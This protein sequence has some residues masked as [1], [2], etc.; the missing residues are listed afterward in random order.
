[1]QGK[2]L[3]YN[4]EFKSGLIRG[5]DGNK[6]RFS[7]DDCKSTMSPKVGADVDF[8]P[9]GDKAIEVY[10]LDQQ[11]DQANTIKSETT[12]TISLETQKNLI[13]IVKKIVIWGVVLFVV[14]IISLYGY[15][16][17]KTT[18]LKSGC[19][20]NNA[21]A[22]YDL[23]S[24]NGPFYSYDERT[25]A[26]NKACRLGN[27]DGCYDIFEYQKACDLKLGK[28]CYESAQRELS[29]YYDDSKT[30]MVCSDFTYEMNR[31]YCDK[32]RAKLLESIIPL[33]KLA[34]EY[35]Y[36]QGCTQYESYK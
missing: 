2:I 5:E 36:E 34:C 17:I 11:T 9:N 14:I 12:P 30:K 1:M 19:E 20:N 25:E 21:E 22:C 24:F 7:I 8:E 28:G 15:F 26:A 3:D 4:N 33:Y 27:A 10:V 35:G 29:I 32:S 31:A 6:Y 13:Q 18:I 23:S 16:F